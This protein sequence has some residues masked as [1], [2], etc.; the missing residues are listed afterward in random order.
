MTEKLGDLNFNIIR[1]NLIFRNQ[2]PPK[3][4]IMIDGEMK[5]HGF[6]G[7]VVQSVPY[8]SDYPIDSIKYDRNQLIIK[9]ITPR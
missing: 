9:L 6:F 7:A 4:A 1:S 2:G 3:I 8:L 5:H